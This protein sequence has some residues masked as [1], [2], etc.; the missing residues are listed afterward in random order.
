MTEHEKYVFDHTFDLAYKNEILNKS[1]S[2]VIRYLP[3]RNIMFKMMR[4]CLGVYIAEVGLWFN[5]GA[6]E[7]EERERLEK[8]KKAL[9]SS[10]ELCK[11]KNI[12]PQS[13][14]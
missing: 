14:W 8:L 9:Q 12:A 5:Q 7:D 11:A 3:T 2:P 1:Y 6:E 13:Y 10:F 4:A